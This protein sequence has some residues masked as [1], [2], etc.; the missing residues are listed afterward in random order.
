MGL[1][2]HLTLVDEVG[3]GGDS[4]SSG[5]RQLVAI[6]RA[7]LSRARVVFMDEPTASCDAHTDEKLQELFCAGFA[8]RTVVCIAHRLN[9]ILGYDRVLVM[10]AGSAVELDAP[11]ALIARPASRFAQMVASMR[12]AGASTQ[13]DDEAL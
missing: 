10:E 9:T 4:L 5:Q 13:P 2:A 3:P 6:A 12:E 11:D 7:T 1:A 8:G